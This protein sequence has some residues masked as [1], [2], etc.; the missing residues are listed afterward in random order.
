[1]TEVDTR[2][3][4][5]QK[6]NEEIYAEIFWLKPSH[7]NSKTHI[8]PDIPVNI[9]SLYQS[10]KRQYVLILTANQAIILQCQMIPSSTY[11][12]QNILLYVFAVLKQLKRKGINL[13]LLLQQQ[14]LPY[15]LPYCVWVLHPSIYP[16]PIQ[17]EKVTTNKILLYNHI[18]LRQKCSRMKN[19][20]QGKTHLLSPPHSELYNF[21]TSVCVSHSRM[22]TLLD[23]SYSFFSLSFLLGLRNK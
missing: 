19:S 10:S 22:N 16:P 23:S 4:S 17:Q 15:L 1:M 3:P 2:L 21:F 5:I 14:Y 13:R 11:H 12:H 7:K 18:K 8:G 20:R 9:V 6:V